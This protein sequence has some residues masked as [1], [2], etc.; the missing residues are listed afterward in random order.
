M[1]AERLLRLEQLGSEPGDIFLR[2]VSIERK[3]TSKGDPYLDLELADGSRSLP[4]K[5]WSNSPG[6]N[7]V[8]DL[9]AGAV[10]KIRAALDE[11]RGQKQLRLLR[12][13]EAVP[14]DEWN[15]E[16]LYGQGIETVRDLIAK[17]L[18]F[19]IE[20]APIR[21]VGEL[22][23]KLQQDVQ[24]LAEDRGWPTEKVL[25]LNPLFSRVV[26]I[27]IGDIDGSGGAVLFAPKDE[28]IE[29]LTKE[30]EGEQWL[31]V[32]SETE[33]LRSFWTLGCNCELLVSYNG[34][35]F[36]L[37]FLR[38]RSAILGVPA[39]RD[40]VSQPP[41]VH[42]PHLDLYQIVTGG[43]RG[44]PMNL[45][46]ACYAFGIESPK[47]AM[48]GSQVGPAFHEGRYMDIARYNL[49][50]IDATRSLFHRLSETVLDHLS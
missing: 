23:E 48:D 50:D 10:V 13:R 32:S 27:A 46:A 33:M 36:D 12:M 18:V 49:A 41:Y 40:F 4:G 38:T 17:R 28:H 11:Y 7:E 16:Q 47:D 35:G 9:K 25:G 19:D 24:R 5:L 1:S 45:D 14:S 34:R 39:R 20:T 22:P 2:L 37:P 44:G 21:A 29:R 8:A 15:P 30:G 42:K 43:M 26:S 6:F 3:R 31:R